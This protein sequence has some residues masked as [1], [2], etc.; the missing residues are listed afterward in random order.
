MALA[1][2]SGSR[3]CPPGQPRARSSEPPSVPWHRCTRRSAGRPS[4]ASRT[5]TRAPARRGTAPPAAGR[6]DQPGEHRARTRPDRARPPGRRRSRPGPRC[7]A[8]RRRPRPPACRRPEPPAPPARTTPS[9]TAPAPRVAARYQSASSRCGHGG[10]SRTH[11]ETPR[12]AAQPVEPA[13]R[14]DL[15]PARPADEDHDQPSGQRRG[16]ERSSSA[17]ARSTTSG[18]F[19]GWIRP[20]NTSTTASAGSPSR[21]RAA[22]R[23]PGRNTDRSTP[24]L[25]VST[26]QGLAP[27][28]STSWRASSRG[29]GDQP[30]GG[31]HDLALAADPHR[32][33]RR[34]R[35]RPGPGS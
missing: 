35:R 11:A 22:G 14:A 19:S 18:P 31:R 3:S 8:R 26:R 17:A 23:E 21:R 7:A 5:P 33:A 4:R 9:A 25:T 28:S 29:V 15:G 12:S 10:S 34:S 24:G 1:A 13:G 20:A 32:R 6:L 16:D 27:Y 30:V 2:A